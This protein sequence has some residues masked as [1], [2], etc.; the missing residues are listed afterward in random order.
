MRTDI[1]TPFASG[2]PQS[3]PLLSR[4]FIKSGPCLEII[5][6]VDNPAQFQ[7]RLFSR[8]GMIWVFT[9]QVS[10]TQML[11]GGDVGQEGVD[12]GV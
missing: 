1:S 2:A 10:I 5:E 12:D 4:R 6:S 11:N 7:V 9:N 8:C 3:L